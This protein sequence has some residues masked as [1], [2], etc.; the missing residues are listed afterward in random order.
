MSQMQKI[1]WTSKF[2]T[3]DYVVLYYT[4]QKNEA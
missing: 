4:A 3:L 1:N 2:D